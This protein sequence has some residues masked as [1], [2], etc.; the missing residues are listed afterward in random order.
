MLRGRGLGARFA[1]WGVSPAWNEALWPGR[2][3]LALWTGAVSLR[4]WV[5]LLA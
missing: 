4:P 2:R 5:E 3:R 1:G